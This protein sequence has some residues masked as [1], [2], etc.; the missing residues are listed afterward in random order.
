MPQP[1]QFSQIIAI[2]SMENPLKVSL[3]VAR[4][5]RSLVLSRSGGLSGNLRPSNCGNPS[6]TVGPGHIGETGDFVLLPY[7]ARELG[8]VQFKFLAVLAVSIFQT[9]EPLIKG[10]PRSFMDAQ[11]D[12]GIVT[13]IGVRQFC[14]ARRVDVK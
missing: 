10:E 14:R 11:T 12:E 1:M 7:R 4:R 5:G 9:I 2:K 8:R 3:L 6:A 13:G